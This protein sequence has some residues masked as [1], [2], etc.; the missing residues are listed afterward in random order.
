[1]FLYE[2]QNRT[3]ERYLS[4]VSGKRTAP[5]FPTFLRSPPTDA[6]IKRRARGNTDQDTLRMS[7]LFGPVKGVIVFNGNNLVID[8]GVQGVRNKVSA[9][10]LNLVGTRYTL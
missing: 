8:V 7:Q 6:R 9:N 3:V 10:P 4:P 1:M 2:C 5:A